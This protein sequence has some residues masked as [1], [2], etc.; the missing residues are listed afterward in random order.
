M[1][2]L[3]IHSYGFNPRAIQQHDAIKVEGKCLLAEKIIKRMIDEHRIIL[4]K[5]NFVLTFSI[6]S[7]SRAF[8]K[9]GFGKLKLW[10][11]G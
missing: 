11:A 4:N 5:K 3:C 8:L 9:K 6:N 10:S 7:K 2:D 1:L